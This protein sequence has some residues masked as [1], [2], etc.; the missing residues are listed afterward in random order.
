MQVTYGAWA[1]IGRIVHSINDDEDA[2]AVADLEEG[3]KNLVGILLTP[4]GFS[5]YYTILRVGE[6]RSCYT[7]LTLPLPPNV[8]RII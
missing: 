4:M 5:L 8:L 3:Q 6:K 1:N 2:G 7:L